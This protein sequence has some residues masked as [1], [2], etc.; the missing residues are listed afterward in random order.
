VVGQTAQF[1]A[2]RYPRCGLIYVL[3][4]QFKWKRVADGV[5]VSDFK[6]LKAAPS[7]FII[8]YQR[9]GDDWHTV[10]IDHPNTSTWTVIDR[11]GTALGITNVND[12]GLCD[13][14]QVDT[15]TPGFSAIQTAWN[16]RNT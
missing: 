7:S 14:W 4:E 8:S 12:N 5:L 15:T 6:K 9:N 13:A 16:N 1:R 11:Q 3:E 2:T 10:F